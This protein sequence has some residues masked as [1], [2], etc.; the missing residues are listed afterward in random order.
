MNYP[1]HELSW[2]EFEKVV[3]SIC[4]EI[5]GTG[6]I[7][8]SDGKDGGRDAKFTGTAN[9]FPSKISPWKGKFIIQAKHTT[10]Q[11]AS[12]SDSDFKGIIL[13][14][15]E[16]II[17]LSKAGKVDNYLLF[18][19]RK[20]TGAEDPK[21]ED[22]ILRE[23]NVKNNQIIGVEKIQ[24]WLNDYPTISKKHNLNKLLMPLEFYEEDL[25]EL[26]IAFSKTDF[27]KEKIQEIQRNNEKIP[28]ESKNE[29]N[30]MG[31]NYFNNVFQKSFNDFNNIKNFLQDPKNREFLNMYNNTI[32][33]IQ[34]K[35]L[36]NKN[37][38]YFFEEAID[39]LYDYIFN[40]NKSYLKNDRR[41]IRVFLHYMY[42]SCDIGVTE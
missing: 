13:S 42:F 18:T 24:K 37:Q 11:N 9:N 21:I 32:S 5:L 25:R 26:I 1:L 6:T 30:N 4:E 22:L 28:I 35:I 2:Q 33:D 39:Y 10:R 41:L 36:I 38:Y 31:N 3:I 29:L 14:E 17:A 40:K 19:N 7:N 12:C 16:N 27:D 34:S 20:L 15:I 23:T 8:F